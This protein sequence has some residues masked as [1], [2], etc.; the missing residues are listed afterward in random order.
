MVIYAKLRT[1]TYAVSLSPS[2]KVT[3]FRKL[4]SNELA[5]IESSSSVLHGC[6]WSTRLFLSSTRALFIMINTFHSSYNPPPPPVPPRTGYRK[7]QPAVNTP[8][9]KYLSVMLLLLMILTFGGFLYL[10]QKLNMVWTALLLVARGAHVCI[11]CR[12]Q[13]I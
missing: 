5:C 6:H 11:Y 8:L 4:H 9:V 2:Q 13:R 1:N 3:S 10:F 7:P 12:L